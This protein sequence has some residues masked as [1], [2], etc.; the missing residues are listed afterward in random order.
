MK[1]FHLFSVTHD[2]A[3]HSLSLETSKTNTFFET[4]ETFI[5]GKSSYADTDFRKHFQLNLKMH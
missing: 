4:N 2:T 5:K 1:T 3:N